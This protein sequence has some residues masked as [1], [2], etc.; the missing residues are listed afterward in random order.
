MLRGE[1]SGSS[2][3]HSLPTPETCAHILKAFFRVPSE[4]FP[5]SGRVCIATG[6]ITGPARNNFI[7]NGSSAGFFERTYGFQYAVAFP[8]AEV[9]RK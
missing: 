9:D 8:R 1:P 7:R 6:D 2:R 4:Q 5:R 3:I